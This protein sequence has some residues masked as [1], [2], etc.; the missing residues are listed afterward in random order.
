MR[1]PASAV[2]DAS[3]SQASQPYFTLSSLPS[4]PGEQSP[5]G[6]SRSSDRATDRKS[7]TYVAGRSNGV[8][9]RAS[10]G[11]RVKGNGQDST[12]RLLFGSSISEAN[13]RR[14]SCSALVAST[15]GSDNNNGSPAARRQFNSIQF[16]K[17][18]GQQ[19]L[20]AA[21]ADLNNQ[22]RRSNVYRIKIVTLGDRRTGKTCVLKR[23]C[24]NVFPGGSRDKAGNEV[25]LETIGV[26]YGVKD[27][28]VPGTENYLRMNMYDL[29]GG[30]EYYEVRREFY[31]DAQ[32]LILSYDPMQR[33]SF[34]NLGEWIHEYNMNN[35]PSGGNGP[36]QVPVVLCATKVS[37]VVSV[38]PMRRCFSILICSQNFLSPLGAARLIHSE[39]RSFFFSF[40]FLLTACVH[41]A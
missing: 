5:K 34:E 11:G 12:S 30:R 33:K 20:F 8:S 19:H 38:V 23:F 21:S 26:D 13:A 35:A 15:S 14:S 41:C 3:E 25:Y 2:S 31:S 22:P 18:R 17:H 16:M 36:S 29:A 32:G 28:S 1:G 40:S 27:I 10:V 39:A 7:K 4:L 24:E 6:G 9:R 37:S